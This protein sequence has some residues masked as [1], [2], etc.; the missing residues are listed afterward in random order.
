MIGGTIVETVL[1]SGDEYSSPGSC[2]VGGACSRR[3]ALRLLR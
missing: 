3:G 2:S 1:F